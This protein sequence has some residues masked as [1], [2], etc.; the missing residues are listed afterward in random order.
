MSGRN[1]YLQIPGIDI[2]LD[3]VSESR[4][5]PTKVVA[6]QGIRRSQR[7]KVRDG[8][9]KT[10]ATEVRRER[11]ECVPESYTGETVFQEEKPGVPNRRPSIKQN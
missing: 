7:G 1:L 11:K 10:A 8:R 9:K 5:P 3:T 2:Y 6:L 4:T